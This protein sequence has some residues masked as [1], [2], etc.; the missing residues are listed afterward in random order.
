MRLFEDV[1][2][3]VDDPFFARA[4][5]LAE[6]GRGATAPNPL[7][8]CVI[9]RDGA[10]VGEGF[11]PRA[12][13]PHAEVFALRDAGAHATDAEVYVTLEPCSHEG[14]TPPCTA[15]LID[16]GVR[17][18]H[19]GMHDPNP[20]ARGGADVLREAG[21]EVAFAPDPEPFAKLNSGW[22][23]RLAV[24]LPQVVAK[25]GASVDGH[26]SFAP[27]ERASITGSS[28]ARVTR[29]L[30]A[31]ADAVVVGAATVIADDPALTVRDTDGLLAHRQPLRIVLVRH[32]VPAPS[33]RVFTDNAAPTLVLAAEGAPEAQL[34]ALPVGVEVER[35]SAGEGFEAA[36]RALAR[37]GLSDILVECGPTLLTV[38]VRKHL[39]DELVVVTA[40]G[41]AG[42]SA[43]PLFLGEPQCS[44]DTLVHDLAPLE[45][46][47]VG[48]V[49]ITVWGPARGGSDPAA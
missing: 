23:K 49:S 48:D 21:I 37:R 33:A 39:F 40:G 13:Q 25:V 44:G 31:A 17:K 32:H 12:G 18:V 45:A 3:Q 10:I 27:G 14:K 38:L 29:R 6:K 22:L 43:P 24:G 47:I 15:A 26:L 19:I 5:L 9:V 28:G 35:F 16:A 2:S 46:G 8:G 20:I 30:R 4:L 11:H 42:A 41:M 1:A 34:S 7:V 36:L